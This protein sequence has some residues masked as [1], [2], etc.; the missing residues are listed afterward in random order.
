MVGLREVCMIGLRWSEHHVGEKLT[1]TIWGDGIPLL[2]FLQVFQSLVRDHP[3]QSF[4]AHLKKK[5]ALISDNEMPFHRNNQGKHSLLSKACLERTINNK[6]G[7]SPDGN[8][9]L[10]DLPDRVQ[11]L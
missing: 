5:R 1:P 9:L 6:G 4:A 3:S 2:C 7:K 11:V 10:V 8:V